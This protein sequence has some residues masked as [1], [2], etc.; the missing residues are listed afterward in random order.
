MILF[1]NC[2]LYGLVVTLLLVGLY[3]MEILAPTIW[4]PMQ[5]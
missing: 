4:H 3:E 2:I 5:P 1:T